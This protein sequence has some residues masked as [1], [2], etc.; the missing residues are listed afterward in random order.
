VRRFEPWLVGHASELAQAGI[1]PRTL[2][3]DA[4]KLGRRLTTAAH[5][6]LAAWLDQLEETPEGGTI[7]GSSHHQSSDSC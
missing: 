5:T 3:A 7:D 6:V 2:R 4:A 1:D